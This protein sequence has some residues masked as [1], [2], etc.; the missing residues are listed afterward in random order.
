VQCR[1]W[2]EI[3]SHLD[4]APTI[5]AAAGEP[6]IVEKLKKGHTGKWA[7]SRSGREEWL[8]STRSD[9]SADE[10]K[11]ISTA[12]AA[13][14]L[15]LTLSDVDGASEAA[16]DSMA[17]G[18]AITRSAIGDAP[19]IVRM[20]AESVRRGAGQPQLPDM[21]AGD[22]A[23]SKDALIGTVRQAVRAIELKSPME[24]EPFKAW[25]ASVAA[26]VCH[27]TNPGAGAQVS[28]DRQDTIDRLADVLGVAR[29]GG[30]TQP[31]HG[32]EEVRHR[33]HTRPFRTNADVKSG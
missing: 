7:E 3:V 5:L 25:L 19:A 31:R 8:M 28:R 10:W 27:A 4:W 32:A 21:A 24:A 13:A 2:N 14:G 6:D 30:R 29:A 18:R 9:Y 23:R 12:P 22:R 17:V 20:L 16:A 11:A 15:A 26:K 1:R 33:Q